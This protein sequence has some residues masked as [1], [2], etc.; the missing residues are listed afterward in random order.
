[1]ADELGQRG[2][3]RSPT[4]NNGSGQS[5]GVD[6]EPANA[7]MSRRAARKGTPKIIFGRIPDFCRARAFVRR[8]DVGIIQNAG[9][10]RGGLLPRAG[11]D[12]RVSRPGDQY[13]RSQSDF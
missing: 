6:V 1:M 8:G 2:L 11:S 5:G 10:L 9:L 7:R 12:G 3:P 13:E 4:C